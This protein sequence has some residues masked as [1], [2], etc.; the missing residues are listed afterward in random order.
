MPAGSDETLQHEAGELHQHVA[1]NASSKTESNASDHPLHKKPEP[2]GEQVQ[3]IHDKA[4]PGLANQDALK[5]VPEEGTKEERQAKTA[6]LN[7]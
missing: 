2:K 7:K 1:D 3:F 5:D 4:T 6:A